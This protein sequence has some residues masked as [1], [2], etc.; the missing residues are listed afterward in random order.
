MSSNNKEYFI[1]FDTN[2]LFQRYESKAD[3]SSFSFNSTYDNLVNMINQLDIYE[4]VKLVIPSVVWRE[5]E[6]QIIEKHDERI[7]AFNKTIEK[8]QFPEFSIS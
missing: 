2:I 7:V 1:I 4:S 5:M 6:K 8:I 3:F